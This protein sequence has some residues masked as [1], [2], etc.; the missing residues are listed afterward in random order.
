VVI[1]NSGAGI[2][3]TFYRP[4][5]TWLADHGFS[6]LTYDYRGIGASRGRSIKRLKASIQDWG[7]K[8]CAAIVAYAQ[9]EYGIAKLYFLG[10]SIGSIL[11]GFVSDTP[12][13]ERMLLISPHTGYSGDYASPGRWRMFLMWHLVMPFLCRTF[14]Y[15]PGRRLGFPED[16][17]YAVAMEWGGRRGERSLRGDERFGAFDGIV[18]SALVLRPKDDAFASKSAYD[19]IRAKFCNSRFADNEFSA[20][21]FIGHFGFFSRRYRESLWT[22]GLRWLALGELPEAT[23][24]K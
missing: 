18:T 24:L 16:L 23:G 15:F 21:Q 1:V 10:H 20:P 22:I 19:R 2:P 3:Q 6:V 13:I 7:S 4:Y 14:G 17:P 12:E 11:P 9:T 5:A 8:D